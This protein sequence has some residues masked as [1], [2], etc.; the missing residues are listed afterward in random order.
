MN[1]RAAERAGLQRE[2]WAWPWGLQL[3]SRGCGL[4]KHTQNRALTQLLD[5]LLVLN[6]QL[7]PGDVNVEPWT[8]GWPFHRGVKASIV[9]AVGEKVGVRDFSDQRDLRYLFGW[10]QYRGA[11][12]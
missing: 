8:L 7:H 5:A 10:L 3:C 12:G 11:A 2:P 1:S 9:L 6:E 4:G